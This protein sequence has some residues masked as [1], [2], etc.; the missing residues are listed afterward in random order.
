MDPSHYRESR[1]LTRAGF[2]HAFFTRQG[3]VSG[4][5]FHSLNL[6]GDVGDEPAHVR[7]NLR[8][9]SLVLGVGPERLYVPRQVHGRAVL[10]LDGS[11]GDA[12][13]PLTPADALVSNAPGLACAVRTADCVP[14]LLADPSTGRVAAI[15]AGWRGVV[16]DVVGA[17]VALMAS[18]GSRPEALIAAIGPH[19]SASAFEVGEEVALLLTRSGAAEHFI[20]RS[21]GDKAHV[22]LAGIVSAQLTRAGL[23]QAAIEQVAG[24]TYQ[25]Q[26]AFFSYRRDG[27]T[28]GRSLSA[29]VSRVRPS[30]PEPGKGPTSEQLPS[31]DDRR[32]S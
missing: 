11:P 14:I 9:V 4:G 8:R 18:L 23:A 27:K 2:V 20:K 17:S 29:I 5:V 22:D 21:P 3:G 28:S 31:T 19:I 16:E 30:A 32:V 24:C 26:A 12:G 1:L 7:E 6:S 13:V 15:H 25:E 10:L